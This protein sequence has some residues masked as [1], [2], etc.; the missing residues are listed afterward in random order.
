[1]KTREMT[2]AEPILALAREF[3]PQG[4]KPRDD[5]AEVNG[6]AQSVSLGQSSTANS[7]ES[8]VAL[9]HQYGLLGL[10]PADAATTVD[11]ES[12]AAA[13]SQPPK[14]KGETKPSASGPSKKFDLPKIAAQA[15]RESFGIVHNAA[16]RLDRR[17]RHEPAFGAA[18]VAAHPNGRPHATYAAA[19]RAVMQVKVPTK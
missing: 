19:L 13:P 16:A 7:A 18:L 3:G 9:A 15:L 10:K 12:L 11:R 1:M 14:A 5:G 2:G 8:I 4:L 6:Q 17:A